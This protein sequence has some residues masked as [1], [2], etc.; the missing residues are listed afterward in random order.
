MNFN[1]IRA[2][3]TITFIEKCREFT[4][5]LSYLEFNEGSQKLFMTGRVLHARSEINNKEKKPDVRKE[6]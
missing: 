1:M 2:I 5:T 4:N 6:E 3:L